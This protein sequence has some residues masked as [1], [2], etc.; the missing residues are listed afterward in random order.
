MIRTKESTSIDGKKIWKFV[1]VIYILILIKLIILKYPWQSLVQ[2][3][4]N[5]EKDIILEGI[6]R[7]NFTLGKSIRMY[8]RY[9][10]KFPFWNGFANLI[11]NILVFIPYGIILPKAYPGCGKWWRVTYCSLGFTM[12]IELFQLFSG[13][14]IFYVDDILLN[15]CGIFL[16]YGMFALLRRIKIRSRIRKIIKNSKK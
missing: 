4:R 14:G 16:G 3:I 7:A 10:D 2:I 6:L 5:W 15:V 8:I 9:F 12:C 11:G 1:F 13:F